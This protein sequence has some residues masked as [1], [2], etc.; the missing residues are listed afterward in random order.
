MMQTKFY[1]WLVSI[2]L[3]GALFLGGCSTNQASAPSASS[4]TSAS[5]A[6]ATAS[7][8]A[9][10]SLPADLSEQFRK[11]PSLAGEATVEMVVKGSPIVIKVDGVNA[12]ITAGNF[13][14]LVNR[15]VYD[16]LAFHR[17][18][19]EPQPFVAQGGD[20]QGKDPSFP[21]DRLGTGSFTDPKTNLPRYIP[22]EIK[23]EGSAPIVYSKTLEEAKVT[24][25]PLLRH[26]TGAVAMARSSP[27]DSASAQ[28][29][30]ALQDLAFLDGNYAVFGYVTSGMEAVQ[31]IQQ[32]DRITSAK[33]TTGIE[34]LR[35]GG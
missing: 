3:V 15:G 7:A 19:H 4:S 30:I 8:S 35:S 5:S 24:A 2:A 33:V 28:F 32:G 27:P 21:V 18:I 9:S 22:L 12:P 25:P 17:V 31:Q 29:Y 13:V 26:T 1:R 6:S 34:N 23:P 16:G 20:P 10:A 11:L 14:D